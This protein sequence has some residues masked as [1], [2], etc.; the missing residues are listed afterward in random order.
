MQNRATTF[1]STLKQKTCRHAQK[2][3]ILQ[4]RHHMAH[5]HTM[6][7]LSNQY[8]LIRSSTIIVDVKSPTITHIDELNDDDTVF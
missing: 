7:I 8:H 1:K 2:K 5:S 4:L 6:K 3:K